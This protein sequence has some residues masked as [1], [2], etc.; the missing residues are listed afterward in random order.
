MKNVVLIFGIMVVFSGCKQD[1]KKPG[2]NNAVDHP[3]NQE[4]EDVTDQV[5]GNTF[6]T[7]RNGIPIFYNM[8]MNVEM[9]TLFRS[10]NATFNPA[11]TNAIDN[12]SKYLTNSKMAM[13]LGVYAV[14][15]SYCQVFDRTDLTGKYL[16]IMQEISVDLGI[17]EEFFLRAAQRF[18]KNVTNKDSLYRIAND[19]YFTT[20]SH[21]KEYGRHSAS[22]MIV[23]GGWVEAMYIGTNIIKNN[24]GDVELL[25]RLYEQQ[26]SLQVLMDLLSVHDEELAIAKYTPMLR[27]LQDTFQT[28]E[29][30]YNQVEMSMKDFRK[31]SV[32]IEEIR[33]EIIS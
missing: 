29:I 11:L 7:I 15:L 16:S 31:I 2:K 8:F 1:G 10:V 26:Y 28:Y 17:P 4:I 25:D 6:D 3:Y 30:D 20:D 9:A 13:N 27:K 24:E 18:E 22:V 32:I 14:D 12:K 21:L 5:D 19:V 23:L 33:N